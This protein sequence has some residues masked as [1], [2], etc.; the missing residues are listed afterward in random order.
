MEGLTLK[1]LDKDGLHS[2]IIQDDVKS[3]ADLEAKAKVEKNASMF[4]VAI[5]LLQL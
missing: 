1:T 2:V 5:A 3:W 4:S